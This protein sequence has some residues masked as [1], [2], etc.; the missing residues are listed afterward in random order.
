[1]LQEHY[2]SY[3]SFYL[4]YENAQNHF[5]AT[6]ECPA[7]TKNILQNAVVLVQFLWFI[8]NGERFSP[9]NVLTDEKNISGSNNDLG[10]TGCG[11]DDFMSKEKRRIP[12]LVWF[13]RTFKVDDAGVYFPNDETISWL[14]NNQYNVLIKKF[15]SLT[16]ERH[17]VL[18]QPKIKKTALFCRQIY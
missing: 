2:A 11:V 16:I 3:M 12:I 13:E 18:F 15:P 8:E 1:M 6:A 9:N 4:V 7:M 17:Q 14:M 10:F 5:L